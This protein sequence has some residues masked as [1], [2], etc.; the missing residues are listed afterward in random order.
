MYMKR[1][2]D[3]EREAGR[4]LF[5]F[6]SGGRTHFFVEEPFQFSC[7]FGIF[8]VFGVVQFTVFKNLLC[9]FDKIFHCGISVCFDVFFQCS[10]I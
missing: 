3:I 5:I 9:I 8:C 10:Q 4:M 2:G 1:R 7:T 6:G